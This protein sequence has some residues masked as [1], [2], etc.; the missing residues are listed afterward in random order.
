MSMK[1]H[2]NLLL[3]LLSLILSCSYRERSINNYTH[4]QTIDL[5]ENELTKINKTDYLSVLELSNL[6]YRYRFLTYVE[7]KY[8]KINIKDFKE[9]IYIISSYDKKLFEDLSTHNFDQTNIIDQYYNVSL[10]LRYTIK[11]KI[12]EAYFP[13]LIIMVGQ[14][15]IWPRTT[16]FNGVGIKILIRLS[17]FDKSGDEIAYCQKR[18]FVN[19]FSNEFLSRFVLMENS[20]FLS[21]LSRFNQED[22]NSIFSEKIKACE[23]ELFKNGKKI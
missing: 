1:I 13:T 2:N 7:S 15:K 5:T 23:Q 9:S 14:G 11:D 21:D 4:G 19:G 3:I 17:I 8:E 10:D 22:K 6:N 16:S 20:P 18:I 12:E